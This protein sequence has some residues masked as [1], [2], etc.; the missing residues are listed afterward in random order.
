MGEYEN[1]LIEL[2]LRIIEILEDICIQVVDIKAALFIT[3]RDSVAL[4]AKKSGLLSPLA[5]G[6]T[7]VKECV[8]ERV[9][10]AL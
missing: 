9:K 5:F 7:G 6:E 10:N 2:P 8:K 1:N 3:Q 4:S